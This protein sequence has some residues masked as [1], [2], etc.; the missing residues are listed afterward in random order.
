MAIEKKYIN[1][2][3]VTDASVATKLYVDEYN[4][5]QLEKSLDIKVTELIKPLPDVNLDLVPKPIYDAEVTRSIELENQIN[6]LQLTIDFLT[7]QVQLLTTDSSSLYADNDNLRIVNAKFENTLYST[8]QTVFELR[9]NLTT[10]LTKALNEATERTALEAENAGLAAQKNALIK[11]IDTLN[12]LL[13][14]ANATIQV[15]Q[16]QLSAKQQAMAAG[17]VST[18]EL[19]TLVWEKG[20]PS[21]NGANGYA[22][23]MDLDQGGAHVKG[24]AG[25][26]GAWSSNFVEIVAGAKDINV[27]ILQ[28]FFSIESSFTLKANATKKIT[29]DRPIQSRVPSGDRGFL[30][31][32]SSRIDYEETITFNVTNT[33]TGG[34]TE[35]KTFKGK[36][37]SYL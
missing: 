22:Y 35:T 20:D 12:N 26:A 18:G 29:F 31:W 27:Q 1:F 36:V 6:D 28:T 13:A 33:D 8:Q 15:A 30:G 32:G 37:H 17:G 5:S 19:A 9:S 25:Y 4:V 14:Q 3:D 23:D 10:S 21:K 34:S 24:P 7:T 11:Q 16:Q 2:S